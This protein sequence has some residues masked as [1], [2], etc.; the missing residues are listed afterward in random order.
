MRLFLIP[1]IV[2]FLTACGTGSS[3][4]S[5]QYGNFTQSTLVANDQKLAEDAAKKLVSLY[6]PASTRF[7]LQHS[8]N[9]SFGN[10]FIE[11][12]RSKGYAVSELSKVTS[13]ASSTAPASPVAGLALAYVVDQPKDTELLQ[14][15]LLVNQQSLGRLYQLKDETLEAAGSWTRK[16]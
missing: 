9:D 1:L 16:E 13:N 8:T 11:V 10:V 15:K 12:L 3:S 7:D 5:G 4:Q 2:V 14:V 6:P